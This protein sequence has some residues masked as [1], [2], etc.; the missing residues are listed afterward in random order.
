VPEP[1]GG[2]PDVEEAPEPGP[3]PT[4]PAAEGGAVTDYKRP[5]S[6]L[7]VIVTAAGEFLLLRRTWPAGFW[8]SVTGSLMRGE[9]PRAAA[10]REVREE[11]GISAPAALIDLDHTERFAIPPRWRRSRYAPGVHY[12]CEHWFALPLA[13]RR[14][15]RLRPREH[16]EYRWLPAARAAASTGSWTN[17]L[18][19]QVVAGLIARP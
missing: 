3:V 18:A 10:I 4:G 9:T 13:Q 8:Q 12:N 16:V 5:E 7:V 17:R 15:V 2:A 6:V 19:I 1:N 11:T 14:I